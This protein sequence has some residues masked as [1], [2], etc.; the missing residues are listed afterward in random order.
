MR[1]ATMLSLMGEIGRAFERVVAER[2]PLAGAHDF[3]KEVERLMRDTGLDPD[4]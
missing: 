2:R 1:V 4:M 3:L